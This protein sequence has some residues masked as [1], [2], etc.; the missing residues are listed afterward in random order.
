MNFPLTSHLIALSRMSILHL[1]P[2][3]IATPLI[4]LHHGRNPHPCHLVVTDEITVPNHAEVMQFRHERVKKWL[5]KVKNVVYDGREKKKVFV[6]PKMEE[7]IQFLFILPLPLS[8][9]FL[10]KFLYFTAKI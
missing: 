8:L 1:N 4:K 6:S 2:L 7:A 10:R 9:I 5:V 3:L